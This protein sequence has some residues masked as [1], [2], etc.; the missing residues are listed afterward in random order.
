MDTLPIPARPDVDQYRKRAK[1]LARAANVGNQHALREWGDHWVRALDRRVEKTSSP[2]VRASI[3]RA[4][5]HV[6]HE[7]QRRAGAS[8]H[9]AL[10]DAQMLI[11]RAH[12]FPSWGTFVHH[13]GQLDGPAADA[14]PFERA[15]DAVVSGDI[16]LLDE[17]LRSHPEL[18]R[19]RS[20]RVHHATLL[21]YLAANGVEDFRQQSPP[22]AVA[23]ARRLLDA[24]VEVDALADTYDGGWWQTTMNLLV[25]SAHPAIAGVQAP[26][27][28]VLADAGAALNGL[29]DDESPLMTALDFGYYSAAQELAR[30]GARVDTVVGAAGLGRDDLIQRF[31]ID[32]DTLAPGVRLAGPPWRHMSNVACD[33]IELALVWACKFG[34]ERIAHGLIEKRVDV[35]AHDGYRM[36]PL[37]YAAANGLTALV[38]ELLRR[39]APLEV[40]NQW[41]GTVLDSTVHFATHMPV[42]GADYPRMIERLLEAG[43]DPDAI[44]GTSGIDQVDRL[45]AR[46]RKR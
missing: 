41:G 25:S 12:G 7:A 18:A 10:S 15:A 17:L 29:R 23:V 24:G 20:A 28:A 9:F 46:F 34:Q 6:I 8:N 33:H 1:D 27:V 35:A 21:H 31:V 22:N 38:D 19:A 36:T 32:A 40:K 5:G 26:L 14:A 11:A 44:Q 42:A 45:L 16:A 30:H 2:F 13:L 3:E 39:G 43:A 4:I 37:H